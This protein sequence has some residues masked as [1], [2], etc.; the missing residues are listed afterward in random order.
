MPITTTVAFIGQLFPESQQDT[1]NYFFRQ[2]ISTCPKDSNGDICS[3]KGLCNPTSASCSCVNDRYGHACEMTSCLSN[4]V[5]GYCDSSTGLCM[6]HPNYQGCDCS[7]SCGTKTFI[8]PRDSSG[9][10]LGT[11]KKK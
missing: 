10:Y 6:C 9:N 4:C 5:N 8:D 11:R 2:F 1:V 7:Q 3:N